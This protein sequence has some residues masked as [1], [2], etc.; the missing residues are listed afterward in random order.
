MEGGENG[1]WGFG[2]I[3]DGGNVQFAVYLHG[4]A[5]SDGGEER[6]VGLC[7]AGGA[8]GGDFGA[9][10]GGFG[11]EGAV[12]GVCGVRRGGRSVRVLLAGDVEPATV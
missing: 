2:D 12:C 7:D 10:C 8:N 11:R 6:G 9:V 1:V 4:G 5:V 3:W